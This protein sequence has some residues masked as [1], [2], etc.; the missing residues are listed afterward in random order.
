MPR[1]AQNQST[2]PC[3]RAAAAA[4]TAG[5]HGRKLHELPWLYLD[6]VGHE[7]GPVPGWRMR[8]WLTLGR[9]PVGSELRVRLPEWEQHFPLHKLFPD[10][11]T[12]FELPPA[13]P[14]FYTEV[15]REESVQNGEAC[16]STSQSSSSPG[17]M[18]TGDILKGAVGR[19]LQARFGNVY[20]RVVSG[21]KDGDAQ[22][23]D[24]SLPAS[25]FLRLQPCE[26]ESAPVTKQERP[27][28]PTPQ[29]QSVLQKLLENKVRTTPPPPQPQFVL[30]N[31]LHKEDRVPWE[32]PTAPF[33]SGVDVL[34]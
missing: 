25:A 28:S 22:G 26:Q 29:A 2:Y 14:D 20:H 5:E 31:L 18:R 16:A 6:G 30:E 17:P 3:A 21:C 1:T 13:W 9:F 15:V 32:S 10:L 33:L 19:S 7:Y 23:G 24:G 27:K 8:Q 11:N 34:G 12:A 4:A